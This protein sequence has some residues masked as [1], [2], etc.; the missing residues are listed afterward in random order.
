MVGLSETFPQRALIF[1]EAVF[2]W[3][4]LKLVHR[5]AEHLLVTARLAMWMPLLYVAWW[6]CHS[7]VDGGAPSLT[8]VGIGE[9]KCP[10]RDGASHSPKQARVPILSGLPISQHRLA[11]NPV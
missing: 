1:A 9:G 5:C 4:D 7:I 11:L 8:G 2:V 3:P 10:G 6:D